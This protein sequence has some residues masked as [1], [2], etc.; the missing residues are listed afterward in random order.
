MEYFSFR[1]SRGGGEVL[2][3]PVHNI[4]L[5]AKGGGVGLPM[6]MY[7]RVRVESASQSVN[8]RLFFYKKQVYKK[9]GLRFRDFQ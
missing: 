8:A 2:D 5:K 4:F 9:L 1:P 7:Y 6:W 3:D